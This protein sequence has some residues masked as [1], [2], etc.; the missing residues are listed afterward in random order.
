MLPKGLLDFS[1]V[2]YSYS[3]PLFSWPRNTQSIN[4]GTASPSCG[5][6]VNKPHRYTL[7]VSPSPEWN[8]QHSP[9]GL[10]FT[11]DFIIALDHLPVLRKLPPQTGWR[12]H[13][14][15]CCYKA[16]KP[17]TFLG[18]IR[19]LCFHTA[20]GAQTTCSAAAALERRRCLS[21]GTTRAWC[22]WEPVL[23]WQGG[24][25][26]SW[27]PIKRTTPLAPF[28]TREGKRQ[29]VENETNEERT[30]LRITALYKETTWRLRNPLIRKNM[31]VEAAGASPVAGLI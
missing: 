19:P 14:V 12:R 8:F 23:A 30:C 15:P 25:K 1:V 11:I 27:Y 4:P 16:S 7:K 13:H 6:A 18:S 10:I 29:W 31:P 20:A 3:M 5:L 28:K 2:S 9:M 22:W 24:I 17:W 21:P 26:V